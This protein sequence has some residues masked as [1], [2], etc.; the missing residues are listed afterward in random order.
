MQLRV[1]LSLEGLEAALGATLGA[2]ATPLGAL[3]YGQTYTSTP[4]GGA[5]ALT[6]NISTYEAW[7]AAGAESEASADLT[8]VGDCFRWLPMASDGF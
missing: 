8:Q 3:L 6:A 2:A 1:V 7:R 5:V 4:V